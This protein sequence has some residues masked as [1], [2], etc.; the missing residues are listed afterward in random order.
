[1]SCLR[2]AC[3]RLDREIIMFSIQASSGPGKERQQRGEVL[4]RS[5]PLAVDV[6]D[7]KARG[8]LPRVLDAGV[9]RALIH[10]PLLDPSATPAALAVGLAAAAGPAGKGPGAGAAKL[11]VRLHAYDLFTNAQRPSDSRKAFRLAT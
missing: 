3:Y 8:E 2:R 6:G 11:T 7:L 10:Q 9:H 5:F 1:M 4:K